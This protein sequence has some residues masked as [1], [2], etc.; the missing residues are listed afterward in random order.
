[1]SSMDL[2]EFPT[3]LLKLAAK[4]RT[5]D[6]SSNKIQALPEAIGSFK[7]LKNLSLNN[8]SLHM[9][10]DS[11][12]K[13]K[14]LETLSANNNRFT[15]LP[16]EINLCT[17]LKTVL[18]S[19]N[20]LKQI[21]AQLSQLKHL[22]MLDLSNND[23]KEIPESM[24]E[25]RAVELNLNKNQISAIPDCLQ[26]CPRLKVLRVEENCVSIKNVSVKVL[27]SSN[28]SLI[29]YEGNL[30][31]RKDFQDLE[32]YDQ[33]MERYTAQ[34]RNS[35]DGQ[36]CNCINPTLLHLVQWFQSFILLLQYVYS[37]ILLYQYHSAF[38]RIIIWVNPVLNLCLNNALVKTLTTFFSFTVHKS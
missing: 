20:K 8:N 37:S 24:H 10:C 17:S 15:R 7:S 6:I 13:L 19:G 9:L 5:I 25:L 38:F 26:L 29:A 36:L 3:Q 31:T 28:I 35:T 18:L 2:N 11:I 22:D 23:I 30:F 27:S 12:S 21:P 34:K 14:K 32:G 16:A 1:L 4:L 33:Y